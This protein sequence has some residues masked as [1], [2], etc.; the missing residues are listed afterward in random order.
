MYIG[1]ES[2]SQR[3][4]DRYN[5]QVTVGQ[6]V[7]TGRLA[8]KHG[9]AVFLSL[10]VGHPAET[11]RDRLATRVLIKRARPVIVWRNP[12]RD[13]VTRHGNVDFPTWRAPEMTTTWNCSR[14]RW[15]FSD[16]SRFLYFMLDIL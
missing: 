3:M 1:A 16:R 13:D 15:S 9:I 12:Y 6:I 4:L 2:G 5:K 14:S 8:R 10:I 7:K 11:W